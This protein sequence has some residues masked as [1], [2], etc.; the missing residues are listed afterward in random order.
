M[1]KQEDCIRLK[2]GA[3]AEATGKATRLK[4]I[5][6]QLTIKWQ[7]VRRGGPSDM[8]R[9]RKRAARPPG[10]PRATLARPIFQANGDVSL[11]WS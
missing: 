2:Q 11:G 1:A 10:V 6:I 5:D 7:K 4:T 8:L 3:Y 9:L